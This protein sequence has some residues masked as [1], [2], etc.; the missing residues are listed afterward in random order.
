MGETIMNFTLYSLIKTYVNQTI[1]A[2]GGGK[3]AYQIALD[4]GF[5]G[6]EQEWLLSLQGQSPYIGEN[7]N[8]FVG[9]LDTGVS[10]I[11]KV[12]DLELEGFYNEKNLIALSHEEILKICK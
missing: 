10:A 8:W 9:T 6:T 5:Q 12:E 4:N 7:G 11:P 2:S 3:S 1:E